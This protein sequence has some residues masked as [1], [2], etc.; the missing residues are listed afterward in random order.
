MRRQAVRVPDLSGERANGEGG[1][2]ALILLSGANGCEGVSALKID[3]ES[4][5]RQGGGG[6]YHGDGAPFI[7][8]AEVVSK[9]SLSTNQSTVS[10]SETSL[11]QSMLFAAACIIAREMLEWPLL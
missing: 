6:A 9:M 7:A 1:V 11:T 5:D 8:M 4:M 2:E 3:G 10:S